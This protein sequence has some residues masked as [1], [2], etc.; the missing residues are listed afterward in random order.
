MIYYKVTSSLCVSVHNNLVAR[1]ALSKGLA[2]TFYSDKRFVEAPEYL[3]A[4]GYHLCIFDDLGAAH[5][6]SF[7]NFGDDIWECEAEGIIPYDKLPARLIGRKWMTEDG[8]DLVLGE[9]YL[10]GRWP[11]HTVMAKKVKLIKRIVE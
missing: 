4:H 1:S 7:E 8:L 3:A 2:L 5:T 11:D 9:S 6:F 10:I